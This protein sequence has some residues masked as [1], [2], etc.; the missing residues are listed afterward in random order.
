MLERAWRGSVLIRSSGR[1]PID[2]WTLEKLLFS[3]HIFP[4]LKSTKGTGHRAIDMKPNK[5]RAQFPPI[6]AKSWRITRGSAPANRMRPVA[7]AVSADKVAAGGNA[8]KR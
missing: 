8:S 6:P 7:A 4:Y 5:D 3:R 1:H 2:S